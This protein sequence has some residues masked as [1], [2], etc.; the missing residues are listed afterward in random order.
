VS[1]RARAIGFAALALVCAALA[2][3]V[4]GDYRGGVEA[5]LGE[6]RPVVVARAAV[7]VRRPLRPGEASELLEVRRVPARFAPVD[8]LADPMEAIGRELLAPIPAG[9][10]VTATQ[11]RE[12]P[13]PG[14][15]Q[16]SHVGPGREAVE[17][18]VT[19]AEALAASGGDPAGMN[20]DVVVTTEPRSGGGP[21]RTYVA[22]ESVRL[23]GLRESGAG[24]DAG[25]LGPTGPTSWIAT[26]GA[27]RNEA[28]RLIQA[29]NYARELR[30]I[31]EGQR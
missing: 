4:A 20:V 30:L 24:G 6:L 31:A 22:A 15:R 28:L 2:A 19:G 12:A 21:G 18:A 25:G 13:A 29:H 10:Y 26:V 11:L 7:D 23:L 16:R 8:A 9:S 5:Q 14:R 17:I 27:S 1:R 3:S